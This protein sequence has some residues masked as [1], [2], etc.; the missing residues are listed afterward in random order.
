MSK[1]EVLA[2]LGE[3]ETRLATASPRAHPGQ[4]IVRFL[5]HYATFTGRSSRSEFWWITLIGAVL[6]VTALVIYRSFVDALDTIAACGNS[7]GC[8]SASATSHIAAVYVVFLII[9]TAVTIAVI[10]PAL[11]LASRRLHDGNH[12]AHYLW[13]TLIPGP[14]LAAILYVALDKTDPAGA[15]FDRIAPIVTDGQADLPSVP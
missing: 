14:G 10:V 4:A 5:R 11:A 13:L 6:T 12:T 1:D 9:T 2:H 8:P 7:Y 3:A 15:R